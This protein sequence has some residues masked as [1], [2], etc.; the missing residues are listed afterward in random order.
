MTKVKY[1][2]MLGNLRESDEPQQLITRQVLG[3]NVLTDDMIHYSGIQVIKEED[4]LTY[5]DREPNSSYLSEGKKYAKL[6][7]FDK[8][9]LKDIPASL[10][11]SYKAT[12]GAALTS[13]EGVFAPLSDSGLNLVSDFDFSPGLYTFFTK[14]GIQFINNSSGVNKLLLQPDDKIIAAGNFSGY[15]GKSANYI[16]RINP[17]GSRDYTFDMGIGFNGIVNDAV[18]LPSGKIICV[19]I[20]T[21]YKDV[22]AKWIVALNSDG[23]IDTSFTTNLGTGFTGAE[24]GFLRGISFIA[25]ALYIDGYFASINSVSAKLTRLAIDGTPDNA[26]M[27]NFPFGLIQNISEIQVYYDGKVLCNG[28]FTINSVTKNFIR[29]NSDGTRDMTFTPFS[30]ANVQ[31]MLILASGDILYAGVFTTWGGANISVLAKTDS[32]GALNTTWKFS[33]LTLQSTLNNV[34]FIKEF[35]DGRILFTHNAAISI[36]TLPVSKGVTILNADGSANTAYAIPQFDTG[37]ANTF[38]IPAVLFLPN[39]KMIFGGNIVGI[40]GYRSNG[41]IQLNHDFSIDTT[42]AYPWTQINTIGFALVEVD[43]VLCL[44]APAALGTSIFKFSIIQQYGTGNLSLSSGT[45]S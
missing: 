15:Q 45:S 22:D 25:N 8:G 42:D 43:G 18:L 20:F 41:L 39:G 24:N 3:T 36:P 26:Y 21:K 30:Q 13:P 12:A 2:K 4:W 35:S 31:K 23:S 32:T 7:Y 37:G 27:A 14:S 16:V 11:F 5:D 6:K 44:L 9:E 10:G 28:L 17:N 1:D 34:N 29:L 40:Y 33:G 38:L 19:G